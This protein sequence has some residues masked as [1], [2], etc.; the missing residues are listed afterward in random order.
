MAQNIAIRGQEVSIHVTVDGRAQ[1]GTWAK[2]KDF[3]VTPRTELI[4][5]NYLGEYYTDLDK[6]YSGFDFS[7]SVDMQDRN[8]IDFLNEESQRERTQQTP[9]RITIQVIYSFRDGQPPVGETY[10]DAVMK[11]SD[12]SIGGRDE[13]VSVSVEGK[14]KS[15]SAL[16]LG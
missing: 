11:I 10:F 14:A 16:T 8:L 13:Y 15:R 9:R 6:Q 7:F 5:Q 1:E 3:T 2:V 12:Q 4:E